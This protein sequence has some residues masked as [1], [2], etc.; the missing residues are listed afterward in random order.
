V[1]V[2]YQWYSVAA[3]LSAALCAGAAGYKL[4]RDAS[5]LAGQHVREERLRLARELHDGVA[6]ELALIA[7]LAGRAAGEE[8]AAID[9]AAARALDECRLTIAALRGDPAPASNGA[10][11]AALDGLAAREGIAIEALLGDAVEF[12]SEEQ[13]DLLRV[14]AESVRNAVHHGGATRVTVQIVQEDGSLVL[15]VSDNGSGFDTEQVR[16]GR[17]GLVGMRERAQ[18]LGGALTVSSCAAG[19]RVELALTR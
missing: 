18:A 6:Q 14:I 13:F 19:T 3:F 10:L 2:A 4:R 17:Y 16:P 7:L 9:A 15:R 1:A 12:S 11:V 5:R 8:A